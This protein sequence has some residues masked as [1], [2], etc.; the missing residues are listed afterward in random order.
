MEKRLLYGRNPVSEALSAG[1]LIS[2]YAVQSQD[3]TAK[4]LMRRIRQHGVELHMVDRHELGNL[5]QT[6]QHQGFVAWARPL[7][8]ASLNRIY[9]L[10]SE[11]L[12][13]LLLTQVQDPQNLGAV[14]RNCEHFGIDAL[15]VGSKGSC[16]WQIPSVAKSSAGAI[17]YQPLIYTSRPE[18]VV[19]ELQEKKFT[20]IGLEASAEQDILGKPIPEK[21][22]VCLV[23]GS[24]GEGI[25]TAVESR[26]DGLVMIPRFGRV[27]SLN[28]SAA[29]VVAAMWLKGF[30]R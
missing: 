1:H 3:R 2:V 9:S 8:N 19:E 13:V 14:I 23:V 21:Q 17:E 22:N 20:V 12:R 6:S 24:E 11:G 18:K 28:L 10:K 16:E 4:E 5:S 26:L 27:N 29:S 30:C 15:V 7:P 25:G